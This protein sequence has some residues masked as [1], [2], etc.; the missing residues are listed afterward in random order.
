[1][2]SETF[3]MCEGS[4]KSD[5]LME[6]R[7]SIHA[8]GKYKVGMER[9]ISDDLRHRLAGSV[10]YSARVSPTTRIHPSRDST[11]PL[12]MAQLLLQAL[13]DLDLCW[14]LVILMILI[15]TVAPASLSSNGHPCTPLLPSW[16]R[17]DI[18]S[19]YKPER[20]MMSCSRLFVRND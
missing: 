5:S 14:A 15:N 17:I 6:Y 12:G 10:G 11:G 19:R 3:N 1:M 13:Q 9:G 4:Y 8:I 20:E 2:S 18:L 16:S 7:M